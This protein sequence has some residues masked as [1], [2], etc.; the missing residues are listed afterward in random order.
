MLLSLGGEQGAALDKFAD[1]FA[2]RIKMADRTLADAT[3]IANAVMNDMKS[4]PKNWVAIPTGDTLSVKRLL[5]M[6]D[7]TTYDPNNYTHAV[8]ASTNTR[9]VYDMHHNNSGQLAEALRQTA[10]KVGEQRV[11]SLRNSQGRVQLRCGR[12]LDRGRTGNWCQ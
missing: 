2:G 9:L 7:G 1:I 3:R 8:Q 5:T 12:D 11:E 4:N 10:E 6:P